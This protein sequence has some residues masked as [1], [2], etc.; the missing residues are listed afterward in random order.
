MKANIESLDAQNDKLNEE[1]SMYKNQ[2][3]LNQTQI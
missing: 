3:Q 2:K 1:I